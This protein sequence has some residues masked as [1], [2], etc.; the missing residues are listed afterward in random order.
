MELE[1]AAYDKEEKKDESQKKNPMTQCPHVILG[2]GANWGS[3][4]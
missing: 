3:R 1:A 2:E 4:K